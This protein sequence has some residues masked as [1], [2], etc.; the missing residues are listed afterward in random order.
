MRCF[1]SVGCRSLLL[2][3]EGVYPDGMA[4]GKTLVTY[5]SSTDVA[6]KLEELLQAPHS[7]AGIADAGYKMVTSQYSKER[8]W[9][10]FQSLVSNL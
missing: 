10:A 4:G 7:M 5:H 3:D 8:Q 9:N 2:S 6:A 1:E